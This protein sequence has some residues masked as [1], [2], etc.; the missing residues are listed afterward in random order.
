MRFL[1]ADIIH[2][3]RRTLQVYPSRI[4]FAS[5]SLFRVHTKNLKITYMLKKDVFGN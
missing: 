1:N 2:N 4:F 5:G 3:F